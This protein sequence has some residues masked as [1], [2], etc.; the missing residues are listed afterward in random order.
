MKCGKEVKL[1]LVGMDAKNGKNRQLFGAVI[2]AKYVHLA[3]VGRQ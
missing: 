1:S 3:V 2:I